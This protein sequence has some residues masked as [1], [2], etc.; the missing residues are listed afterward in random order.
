MEHNKDISPE[1]LAIEP[2][3]KGVLNKHY[4]PSMKSYRW[5]S[6]LYDAI[7][8]H[9]SSWDILIGYMLLNNI[10]PIQVM[11]GKK[12]KVVGFISHFL[13][14]WL[15]RHPDIAKT[16]TITVIGLVIKKVYITKDNYIPMF[17]IPN[18]SELRAINGDIATLDLN[19]YNIIKEAEADWEE[20]G[21]GDICIYIDDDNGVWYGAER[22]S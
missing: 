12:L 9:P 15:I 11:W 17:I 3:W 2:K 1:F 7:E 20:L 16:I 10:M 13:E 22:I 5:T 18:N 4:N 8:Q 19:D 6:L 14:E 21:V